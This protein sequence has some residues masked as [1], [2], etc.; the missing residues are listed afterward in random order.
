MVIRLAH[1]IYIVRPPSPQ[2]I[3]AETEIDVAVL[4]SDAAEEK[5]DAKDGTS[6]DS[7]LKDEEDEQD[8]ADDQSRDVINE[9]QSIEES[10]HAPTDLAGAIKAL[11]DHHFSPHCW[12]EISSEAATMYVDPDAFRRDFLYFEEVND[13]LSAKA[14]DLY[15]IYDI[16]A[17]KI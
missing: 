15:V 4:T 17:Q 8:H 7:E 11:M 16:Y 12:K 14:D 2:Q 5:V 6:H 1:E 3:E 9:I 13:V 10:E